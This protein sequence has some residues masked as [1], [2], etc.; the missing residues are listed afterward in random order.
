MANLQNLDCFLGENKTFTLYA[1]D[2][3]NAPVDLTGKTISWS[4]ARSPNF[5][6]QN[7]AIFTVAGVIVNAPA[8]SFT[9]ALIPGETFNLTPGNYCHQAKTIDNTGGISVVTYGTLR[10]R[11]YISVA[12]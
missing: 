9:V 7:V 6:W 11:S 3:S 12:A 5:P 1:R 10:L 8:G 4:V 2:S